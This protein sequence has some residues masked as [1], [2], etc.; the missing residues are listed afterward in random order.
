M[1][2]I[3]FSFKDDSPKYKK[4]YKRFKLFIE[5]GDIL[6]DEQLP[7][8][9]QLGEPLQVSRNTTLMAYGQLAAKGYIREEGLSPFPNNEVLK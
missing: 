5:R 1:K 8:I 2:N 7:S 4:I 9:R 6:A 3:I